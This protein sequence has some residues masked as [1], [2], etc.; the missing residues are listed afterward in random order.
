MKILI[1]MIK[2]GKE[3]V[4]IF[5]ENN[6]LSD[7]DQEYIHF[8]GFV[9]NQNE[10]SSWT[11]SIKQAYHNKHLVQC[12]YFANTSDGIELVICGYGDSPT[13][14]LANVLSTC[15]HFVGEYKFSQ[16]I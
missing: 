10:F 3:V 7:V 12:E 5:A 1:A 2:S 9:L 8:I 14:A 15:Q 6:R 16:K 11:Y 13:E 4:N